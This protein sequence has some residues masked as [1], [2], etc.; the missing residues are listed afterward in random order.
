MKSSYTVLR[1]TIYVVAAVL[2]ALIPNLEKLNAEVM[3][4][5]LWPQWTAFIL[6]PVLVAVI[7]LRAYVDQS[8]A[9]SAETKEQP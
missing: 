8:A 1:L 9:R 5:M 6:G 2:S 7:T 4:K 3:S